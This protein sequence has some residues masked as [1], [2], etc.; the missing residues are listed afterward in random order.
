MLLISIYTFFSCISWLRAQLE[1]QKSKVLE[2]K[3]DTEG[4][5]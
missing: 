3:D 1:P 5:G 4:L 2:K